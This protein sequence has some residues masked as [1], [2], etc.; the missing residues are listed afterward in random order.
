MSR[1]RTSDLLRVSLR[2]ALLQAAWNTETLQSAGLAY[3]LVPGLRRIHEA[4]AAVNAAIQRYREPFNTHPFLA[5][6]VAGAVLRRE[7]EGRTAKEISTF[8]HGTMGPL[9]AAGDPFFKGGLAPAVAVIAALVALAAG[10]LAGAIA[11]V[12]LFNVVHVTIRVAGVFVGHRR[13][14]R[15]IERIVRWIG[16]ARTR[17]LRASTA[18]LG[19]ALLVAAAAYFAA[20]APVTLLLV[21][22]AAG[23]G[24]AV[25]LALSRALW[26]Y[27]TFGLLGGLLV[28]GV[29]L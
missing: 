13:D 1:L 25:V 26:A 22:G 8:V 9:A 5:G 17:L 2:L 21:V 18:G 14:A 6:V 15:G 3:C 11:L 4:N 7:E 12:V 29:L 28:L 27:S 23:L 10:A 16:P 19:G 24:C 20:P